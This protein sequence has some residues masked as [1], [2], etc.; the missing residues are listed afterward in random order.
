MSSYTEDNF[1]QHWMGYTVE[2]EIVEKRVT[3]SFSDYEI[4][5][6]K[7]WESLPP[8]EPEEPSA[9]EPPRSSSSSSR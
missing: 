6:N 5:L 8:P 1:Q 4:L 3:L 9:D 7:G 2:G